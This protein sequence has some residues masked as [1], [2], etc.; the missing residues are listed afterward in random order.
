MLKLN[1][2]LPFDPNLTARRKFLG[3]LVTAYNNYNLSDNLKIVSDQED[4]LPN[5]T[6]EQSLN[7]YFNVG[8]EAIELIVHGM[9]AAGKAEIKSILDLPCGFGRVARHLRHF[10]PTQR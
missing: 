2:L 9:I 4:M 7:R 3:S 5:K 1:S 6:S 8:F 10:S